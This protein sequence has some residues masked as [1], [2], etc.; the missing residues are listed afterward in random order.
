MRENYLFGILR[1]ASYMKGNDLSVR[2]LFKYYKKS[3]KLHERIFPNYISR[4]KVA[5]INIFYTL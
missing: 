5:P 3:R 1:R 4:K 2:S